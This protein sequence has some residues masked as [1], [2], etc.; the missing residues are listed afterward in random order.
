MMFL[1]EHFALGV[2]SLERECPI[3]K[4]TPGVV[5]GRRHIGW[6]GIV[7]NQLVIN[8]CPDALALYDD[9]L[10]EPLV[11][12]RGRLAH[13]LVRRRGLPYASSPYGCC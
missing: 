5:L 2:M 1:V 7:D 8:V 9:A 6:L 12:C 4:Y 3:R 10:C 13:V 11:V